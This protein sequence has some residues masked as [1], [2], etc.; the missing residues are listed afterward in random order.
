[1]KPCV[2]KYSV[3]ALLVFAVGC[4]EE[5]PSAEGGLGQAPTK[6]PPPQSQPLPGGDMPDPNGPI[7]GTPM[8]GATLDAKLLVL[9]ANGKEPDLAAIVQALEF[10]G[11][12]YTVWVVSA[13]PGKLTA[14]ALASGTHGYY[15]GVIAATANVSAGSGHSSSALSAAE[16]TALYNYEATFAVRQVN[17]YAYPTVM[18]GFDSTPKELDTT[19]HPLRVTATPAAQAIFAYLNTA[20]PLV[21][22]NVWA[23]LA[24]PAASA[25]VTPLLVDSSGN[26]IAIAQKYADG[27]E[28]IT[29]TVDSDPY[30]THS[31][32]LQY[33]LINWVTK[34]VFIGE[35][36][37][38]IGIQIDDLL[39]PSARWN[40]SP[41]YRMTA[42]DLDA[43]LAWQSA[44]QSQPVTRTLTLNW[45]FN[46]SG[47]YVS[48]Q[49]DPLADSVKRLR[50]SF[51]WL[52]HTFTHPGSLSP[53]RYDDVVSE[54][55]RNIDFA[56]Q[57]E[58]P[59]FT[60][61]DLVTPGVSG[62]DAADSMRAIHDVGVRYVVSDTSVA[63]QN[64][65]S[66]NAGIYN[67]F[68]PSVLEIPRQPTNLGYNVLTP[69]EWVSEY[70]Y[71][72]RKEWGRDLS[73]EEILDVE[74][75]WLLLYMLRW[76][77]DPWMFH[78]ENLGL[79]DGKHSL[80]TNLLDAALQKY[81]AVVT[82][83]LVSLQQ[84]ELGERVAK[85][86][87]FNNSGVSGV[88]APGLSITITV[89]NAATVPVTGARLAGAESYAGQSISYASLAAGQSV[90]LPLK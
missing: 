41:P 59:Q 81:S 85:R 38:Y 50:G 18:L 11:T 31:L 33:G 86:M 76:E 34:G 23:Y 54:L 46:G 12:P 65:P 70:N 39:L 78:Q 10:L 63:G 15:Q 66:P 20:N 88:I 51:F 49:K 68:Q 19:A 36:H 60:P 87:Q 13:N 89:R 1:M 82:T 9:S 4:G 80:L 64:N 6:P 79:Y 28:F 48:G 21:I 2:T 43:A 61:I 73:Y 74:S 83:P 52:N 27:R 44:R 47:A 45:A 67:S 57:F 75:D 84:H 29:L 71:L 22:K 30:L 3:M 17:W 7:G 37:A 24:K 69:E 16:W 14:S 62:L 42:A 25:Q 90:T 72:F 40:K 8:T 56:K 35:R 26:A 77:T 32:A 53:M 55:T 5:A 58:L